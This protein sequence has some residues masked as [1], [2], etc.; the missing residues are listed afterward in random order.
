M[1]INVNEIKSNKKEISAEIVISQKMMFFRLSGEIQHFGCPFGTEK[2]H[3]DVIYLNP[4]FGVLP[5]DTLESGERQK[6]VADV[7]GVAVCVCHILRIMSCST[8]GPDKFVFGLP[9]QIMTV[10]SSKQVA[11]TEQPIRR[12]FQINF[13]W[14]QN[15]RSPAKQSE[16]D[17][18]RVVCMHVGQ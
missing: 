14:Q 2:Y 13:C 18:M 4:W 6:T 1:Q 17:F 10:I 16:M 5:G 15:E 9:L 7:V 11:E 8:Y 12:G 3:L